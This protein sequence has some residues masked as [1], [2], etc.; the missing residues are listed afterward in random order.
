MMNRWAVMVP[1]NKSAVF[2]VE[3]DQDDEEQVIEALTDQ[4]A[5]HGILM[6][7]VDPDPERFGPLQSQLINVAV[8]AVSIGATVVAAFASLTMFQ[9]LWRFW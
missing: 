4:M 8:G 1:K 9:W 6:M 2:H 5:T 3:I 7:R